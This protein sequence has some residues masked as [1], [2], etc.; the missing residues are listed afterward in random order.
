VY[1]RHLR[2]QSF[3]NAAWVDLELGP[4]INVFFGP[5]A[6][7]KTN[8]LEALFLVA[9][10]KSF[11]GAKSTELISWNQPEARIESDIVRFGADRR[12]SIRVRPTGKSISIDGKRAASLQESFGHVHAVLFAPEDLGVSKG[13]ASG[14]RV[15]LDRA[16]FNVS[17]DYWLSLRDY[18]AALK[19]R[20]ALLQDRDRRGVDRGLL[21]VFDAQVARTGAQVLQARQRFVQS[22]SPVA[23]A[24]HSEIAPEGGAL[25]LSYQSSS[26]GGDDLPAL[27][28]AL[29]AALRDT[30]RRDLARKTTS[31]G[32]HTDDLVATIDGRLARSFASQ[33]QHRTVVLSLKL[34]E[35]DHAE[36]VLG[37]RPILLLDDVSSELDR[38]RNAALLERLGRSSGQV[39]VTTTDPAY[40]GYV[41]N[42]MRYAVSAGAI[43]RVDSDEVPA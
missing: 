34:A 32:P 1:I 2:L 28:A 41:G 27:E 31:V 7:G 21:A 30:L 39:I 19:S 42:V 13:P 37:L 29:L 10:L 12:I 15:F 22:F 23:C 14:R 36:K 9:T 26:E 8:L 40:L 38:A 6:Q 4:S 16:I 24:V 33:G 5:N 25:C 11:R 3:R 20:N 43:R 17:P 18:E 35:L